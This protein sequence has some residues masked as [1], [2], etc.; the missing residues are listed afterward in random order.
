MATTEKFK[1]NLWYSPYPEELNQIRVCALA[2]DP[3]L[4]IVEIGSHEGN[5]TVWLAKRFPDR[6]IVA[7]DPW[8][9]SQ[10]CSTNETFE[11]FKERI[12]DF[13]NITFIKQK[14]EKVS[15][16]KVGVVFHD[17]N[18]TKPDFQR[19]YNMLEDKG[20]LLV[21]DLFDPGWPAIRE[22]FDLLPAPRYEL[23]FVLTDAQK[24]GYSPGPRGMGVA[25]KVT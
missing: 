7:I 22:S 16:E 19:W 24:E 11:I 23:R 20:F 8:D 18:H 4:T 10:D 15:L 3:K 1:E 12:K 17:G 2:T 25:W 14:S 9:G 13:N 5:T 21:H 6:R